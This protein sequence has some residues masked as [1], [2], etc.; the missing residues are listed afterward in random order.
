MEEAGGF[1]QEQHRGKDKE[2]GLSRGWGREQKMDKKQREEKERWRKAKSDQAAGK[3]N[4]EWRQ[5]QGMDLC[6][7]NR[8]RQ[9][10]I[11]GRAFQGPAGDS[12]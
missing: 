8:V 9:D 12:E 5:H 11:H 1:W 6:L 2:F 10:Q 3:E 7:Y 4:V